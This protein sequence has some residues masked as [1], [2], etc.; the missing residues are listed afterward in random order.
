MHWLAVIV[1][2]GLVGSTEI[3]SRYRDA[4]FRALVRP[5]ALVYIALN[6]VASVAALGFTQVFGLTFGADIAEPRR[7]LW[8]QVLAAG[9]GAMVLFRTALFTLRVGDQDVA[10]GPITVLQTILRAVDSAVDRQSAQTRSQSVG[11]IMGSVSFQRANKAL[12]AYC[13]ALMQNLP[14]E[15]QAE[16]GEQTK[17]LVDTPD[18]DDD[19]KGLLL[20]LSLMNLV[21][22]DVLTTAVQALHG[23]I[24]VSSEQ[25][26]KVS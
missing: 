20:G 13:F 12:P 3:I 6:A 8:T 11:R 21:G 26:V 14:K 9:F 1:L 23:K 22:E 16:F 15:L 17:A 10:V 7:L 18:V 2:G 5:P 19:V 4:P 25:P 24:T